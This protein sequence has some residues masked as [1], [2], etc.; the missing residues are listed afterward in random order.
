MRG[1]GPFARLLADLFALSCKRAGIDGG[2]PRLSTEAFRRPGGAQR[3]LF[4]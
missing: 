4:E 2:G 1:E 3:M